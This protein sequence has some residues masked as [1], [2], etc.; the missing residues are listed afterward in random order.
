MS[1]LVQTINNFLDEFSRLS[2]E[3]QGMLLDILKKR[4]IEQK[5]M[6]IVREVKEAQREHKKGLTKRGTVEDL[7]RDLESD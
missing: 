1:S 6:R 5:R 4:N 3:D 2:L 7:M